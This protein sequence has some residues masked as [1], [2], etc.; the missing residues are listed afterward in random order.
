MDKVSIV[1]P[2]RREPLL[3]PTIKDLL[4]KAKGEIEV[5]AV[6]E[7][8][9]HQDFFLKYL[10]V[11]IQRCS[12]LIPFL[13]ILCQALHNNVIEFCRYPGSRIH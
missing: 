9:W 12:G 11:I 5:I 3:T 4:V 7:G 2:S 13:F 8:Y 1:I 10:E 6:L